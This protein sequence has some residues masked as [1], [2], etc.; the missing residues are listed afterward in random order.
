MELLSCEL[1]LLVIGK[2]KFISIIMVFI[3]HLNEYNYAKN[4]YSY[5]AEFEE[6]INS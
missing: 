4:A 6:H 1:R 2:K 3:E 5:N